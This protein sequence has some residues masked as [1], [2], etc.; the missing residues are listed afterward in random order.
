V[1]NFPSYILK[2]KSIIKL[3][4]IINSCKIMKH[5]FFI[6]FFTLLIAAAFSADIAYAGTATVSWNANTEPDLAGYKIYYGTSP[7][8][9]VCP[10]GGYSSV[11]NVGNVRTYTFNN[12][13]QGVT[14][15]FSVTAYDTSNNESSCSAEV[16]KFIADT[17]APTTPNNLSSTAVSSSQINLSWTASTDNVK[18]TGYRIERCQGSGCSDFS[19]IA[20]TSLTSYSDTGLSASTLYRYRVRAN[21]T[22]GNLS[23]PSSMF[24]ASTLQSTAAPAPT[25][26]VPTAPTAP[27]APA[28]PAPTTP[29]PTA[30]TAPAAPAAPA[31]TTA[32]IK[33]L[34]LEILNIQ[35]SLLELSLLIKTE[36]QNSAIPSRLISLTQSINQLAAKLQT[37]KSIASAIFAR[38]LYFGLQGDDIRNLQEF[39]AKDKTIYPEA[40]ITGYF[41][42][43]TQAAIQRFQCKYN[44]VCSGTPAS[45]G[46]GVVGPRTRT[47]LN[48]LVSQ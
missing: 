21:D 23:V 34:Q 47:K 20:T 40:R 5:Y 27:A 22:A 44:I 7:R 42:L 16:S 19:Q 12:L 39:L 15:Y 24:E 4:T 36:P 14:Y 31:P 18:V 6:F 1:Y 28:A 46:Y 38:N 32:Q 29:V 41:G 17:S 3:L 45:T 10:P 26:P 25:T 11:I 13:V 48:E 9:G 33:E 8:S 43:L 35:K 2:I 30:P 37:A